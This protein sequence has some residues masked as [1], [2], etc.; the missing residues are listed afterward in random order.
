MSH[1]TRPVLRFALALAAL[2]LLSALL[3]LPSPIPAQAK[4]SNCSSGSHAGHAGSACPKPTHG[5]ATHSRTGKRHHHAKHPAHKPKHASKPP[6][7]ALC[8]DGSRALA[9]AGSFVCADGSEPACEDGAT[10]LI[11]GAA[12]LC[13][14]AAEESSSSGAQECEA[15]GGCGLD[16]E[17]PSGEEAPCTSCQ[18]PASAVPEG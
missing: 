11:H 5:G 14:A 10:P 2:G 7:S 18:A 8:E 15:E 16:F 9:V 6:A 1:S 3:L 4:S 17:G 13:P 12:L